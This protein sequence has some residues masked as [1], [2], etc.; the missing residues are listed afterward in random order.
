MAVTAGELTKIKIGSAVLTGVLSV[1]G[2]EITTS[3]IDTTTIGAA[4]AK[5]S[6]PSKKYEVGPINIELLWDSK[7]TVHDT[8]YDNSVAAT[9]FSYEEELED[10]A[11]FAGTVFV[12][13]GPPNKPYRE[14][15]G[16]I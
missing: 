16:G 5:T 1:D 2:P 10:G 12:A 6:R 13:S 3:K 14:R 11:T 4:G 9:T 15:S 8:L 7:D